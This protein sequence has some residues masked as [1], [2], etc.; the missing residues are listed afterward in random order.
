MNKMTS[1]L[2]LLL[3]HYFHFFCDAQEIVVWSWKFETNVSDSWKIQNNHKRFE[4]VLYS[5]LNSTV[6]PQDGDWAVTGNGANN[7][8]LLPQVAY[9]GGNIKL[10]FYAFAFQPASLSVEFLQLNLS[11]IQNINI[12]IQSS[13][14]TLYDVTLNSNQYQGSS[15][16]LVSLMYSGED[17]I[18]MDSI[19]IA[20][21]GK[22]I[23]CP[24]ITSLNHCGFDTAGFGS[25]GWSFT[26]TAV[27][28]ITSSGS[29]YLKRDFI[30][31][32]GLLKGSVNIR[33][34]SIGTKV[35]L[36]ISVNQ[37]S[38]KQEISSGYTNFDLTANNQYTVGQTY[39]IL[40]TFATTTVAS[41]LSSISMNVVGNC[42]ECHSSL[43]CNKLPNGV[44]CVC[45]QNSCPGSYTQCI[46]S[47]TD[48]S[49]NPCS[50][51][52][53]F[54]ED[55]S[56]NCV[57]VNECSSLTPPCSW[58]NGVCHNINGSYSCSCY[59]GWMLGED[60][61][62]C[63]DVNECSSLTPPCSW[64]NGVCHN[65]NGSYSCSCYNGWML[66]EDNASC[67]D[68]DECTS[69]KPI[70]S[71]SNGVCT[72]TN[73]S[74]ACSCKYGWKLGLDNTSCIGL[75]GDCQGKNKKC[76][77]KSATEASCSNSSSSSLFNFLALTVLSVCQYLILCA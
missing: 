37:T 60:N 74:F 56:G 48:Q 50:C 62:S 75:C 34:K 44:N 30:Y 46:V 5:S 32:G 4:R 29:T 49:T 20:I 28:W 14:W 47:K 12:S 76:I 2:V 51:Q 41:Q 21:D 66:G 39:T 6:P 55:V 17:S 58:S 18:Y 27:N 10:T 13:S 24:I 36:E 25:S 40:I 26:S 43:T 7:E 73:G 38:Y 35:T 1:F 31:L 71:W 59:N 11:L 42:S 69:I 67:V 45:N 54:I 22:I 53:G 3:L 52:P 57:G 16:F 33:A 23:S 65:I 68:I 19:A 61:A 63:V 9:Y 64:S 15:A 72:N 70:C 8:L 77:I